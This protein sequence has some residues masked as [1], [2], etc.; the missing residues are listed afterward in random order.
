MKY[1]L[2]A[3][4][5]GCLFACT[6]GEKIH[7][8]LMDASLVRIDIVSRYPN[9][10]QKMLTWRT[11]GSG[12]YITFEPLTTKIALGTTIKAMLYRGR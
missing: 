3:L 12:D 5:P 6:A 2:A 11:E 1:I 8:S 10:Q 9:V 4:V 7:A